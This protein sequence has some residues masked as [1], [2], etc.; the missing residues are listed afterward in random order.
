MQKE[1]TVWIEEIFRTINNVDKIMFRL[2]TGTRN[3][4]RSQ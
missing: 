3:Y 1:N 2:E 4:E